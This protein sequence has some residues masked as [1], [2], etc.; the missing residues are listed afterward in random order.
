MSIPPFIPFVIINKMF[1]AYP[2]KIA[3]MQIIAKG[4]IH[5]PATL[6]NIIPGFP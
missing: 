2:K 4:F 1:S 5:I 6:L 3:G